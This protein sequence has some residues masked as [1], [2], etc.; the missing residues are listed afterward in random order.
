[1]QGDLNI[2]DLRQAENIWQKYMVVLE[3]K[4]RHS[5]FLQV[6]VVGTYKFQTVVEC[7]WAGLFIHEVKPGKRP[8][9]FSKFTGPNQITSISRTIS[10][11][12]HSFREINH[13][14]TVDNHR[15]K[16]E[17]EEFFW[18]TPVR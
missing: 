8:S 16:T 6:L 7:E 15:Y 14:D 5:S 12:I 4:D 9:Y 11:S 2:C 10:G 13:I 18:N 17:H 1:M 3:N